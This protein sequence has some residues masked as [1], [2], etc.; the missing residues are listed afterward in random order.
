MALIFDSR[1]RAIDSS[2]APYSGALLYIYLT[3]TTTL[4]DLY[5]DEELTVPQANPVVADSSGRFPQIHGETG[6]SYDITEKTSGGVTITTYEGVTPFA[7]EGG[8]LLRT[9]SGARLRIAAGDIGDGTT[10]VN[11]EGGEPTP[12]NTGGAVRVGGYSGSQADKLRLDA[13][14]TKI[15]GTL[16]VDGTSTLTGNVALG[17]TITLSDG[18]VFNNAGTALQRSGVY[19]PAD[20]FMTLAGSSGT[21]T[22]NQI[23]WMPFSR[24]LTIDALVFRLGG[25]VSGNARVG[26]YTSNGT[27]GL[28]D[29]QLYGSSAISINT[30]GWVV[31]VLSASHAVTARR[32]IAFVSDAAANVQGV[33][34]VDDR[35]LGYQTQALYSTFVYAAL[36]TTAPAITGSVPTGIPLF[37]R[38]A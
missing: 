5:T 26:L 24:T 30:T 17:G 10:G 15:T 14:A 27:T 29:Q 22:A 25:P 3:G 9:M 4:A 12:D 36:P 20:T 7:S 33:Q 18:T 31:S 35:P 21:I 16:T 1:W 38:G 32:W 19:Y 28:P 11:F 2:G 13:V 8:T 34:T 37:V 23:Y 6:L